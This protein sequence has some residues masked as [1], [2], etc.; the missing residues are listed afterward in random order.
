MS[1]GECKDIMVEGQILNNKELAKRKKLEK[2]LKYKPVYEPMFNGIKRCIKCG[3]AMAEGEEKMHSSYHSSYKKYVEGYI[4]EYDVDII[5]TYSTYKEKQGLLKSLEIFIKEE[6]TNLTQE[7]KQ[8]QYEHYVELLMHLEYNSSIR[9]YDFNRLHPEY[10]D[11]KVLLWNTE[12]FIKMLREV[13]PQDVLEGY[14]SKNLSNRK[15]KHAKELVDK[16]MIYVGVEDTHIPIT[17]SISFTVK[18]LSYLDNFDTPEEKDEEVVEELEENEN[19][20]AD[21]LK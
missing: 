8:R 12:R 3:Y 16:Y 21:L 15:L 7:E 6:S 18:D 5:D 14:V 4:E 11:Y 1:I 13:L 20:L 17:D 2:K 19:W 10:K 9:F